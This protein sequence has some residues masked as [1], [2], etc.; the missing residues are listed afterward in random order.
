MI[1]W[2]FQVGML[3]VN[4]G[5]KFVETKLFGLVAGWSL[6]RPNPRVG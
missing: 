3:L 1:G 5:S 2:H 6:T 4:K